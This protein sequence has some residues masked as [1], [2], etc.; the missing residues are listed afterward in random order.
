MNRYWPGALKVNWKCVNDGLTCAS[1]TEVPGVPDKGLSTPYRTPSSV[2]PLGPDVSTKAPGP[3]VI[4]GLRAVHV[5]SSVRIYESSADFTLPQEEVGDSPY[6][7][8]RRSS[9]ATHTSSGRP[10]DYRARSIREEPRSARSAT[11]P[12]RT[13]C[14]PAHPRRGCSCPVHAQSVSIAPGSA[15]DTA[16]AASP[17]RHPT[18]GPAKRSRVGR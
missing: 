9:A 16:A 3:P 6:A 18:R 7:D 12:L 5:A 17:R 11:V 14:W 8:C 13:N 1:G 4:A 2:V 15:V 10:G